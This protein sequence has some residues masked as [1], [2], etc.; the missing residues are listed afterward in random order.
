MVP[1]IS[2]PESKILIIVTVSQKTLNTR[3]KIMKFG[4]NFEKKNYSEKWGV[5]PRGLS[6]WGTIR[7]YEP[8]KTF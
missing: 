3:K 4:V 8:Y 2:P 1:P 6:P 7:P 5:T